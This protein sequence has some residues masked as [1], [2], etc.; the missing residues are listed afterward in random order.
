MQHDH[1][2]NNIIIAHARMRTPT[3]ELEYVCLAWFHLSTSTSFLFYYFTY[4]SYILLKK[5]TNK[6]KASSIQ[7]TLLPCILLI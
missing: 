2:R 4:S 7:F 3:E 6:I 1:S 5:I